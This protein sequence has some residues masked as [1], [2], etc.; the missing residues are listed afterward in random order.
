MAQR[1]L[2]ESIITMLCDVSLVEVGERFCDFWT[3]MM[4]CAFVRRENILFA[5]S[6]LSLAISVKTDSNNEDRESVT[7][8]T[9]S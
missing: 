8:K 3:N 4:C 1:F 6:Y 2:A 5:S 7:K 9:R